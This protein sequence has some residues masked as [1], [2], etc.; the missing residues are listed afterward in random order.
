MNE[1]INLLFILAG[2]VVV[3]ILVLLLLELAYSLYADFVENNKRRGKTVESL[4]REVKGSR[5]P[6][7]DNVEA[8]IRKVVA[9]GKQQIDREIKSTIDDIADIKR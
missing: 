1:A 5:S 4:I 3:S 2:V 8:M 9:N 7:S 6:G